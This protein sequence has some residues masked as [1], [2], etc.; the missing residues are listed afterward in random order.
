MTK[1][2]IFIEHI[3]GLTVCLYVISQFAS[4]PIMLNMQH[5]FIIDLKYQMHFLR[6]A[7]N[8]DSEE[9]PR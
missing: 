2:Y 9:K 8:V 6:S 3:L 5:T 1:I 4:F 7:I